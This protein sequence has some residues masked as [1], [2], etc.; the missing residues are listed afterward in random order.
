[1]D[2]AFSAQSGPIVQ[3]TSIIDTQNTKSVSF[4]LGNT[5]LSVANALRRT[6][7]AEVPTVAIDLVEFESNSSVLTDE[8]LAHR[9]GL[10]PLNSEQ[11]GTITYT[12]DCSCTQYCPQCSVELHL[13][14]R[15][16]EE[17][18]REVTSRDLISSHSSIMP[19]IHGDDDSGI[20]IAKLR[21]GQEINLRCIAKKGTAKEHAKW[22]PC[23][24]IAF[25]YD[26]HNR[27]RHTTY[28]VEDDIKSEWP[29]SANGL[30][31]PEVVDDEPFD[32]NAKPD[33]FYMTV[34]G[35]GAIDP[36]EIVTTALRIMQTKL[37]LVQMLIKEISDDND[38]SS[39]AQMNGM[40]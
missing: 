18:T 34:E 6:M 24:G 35:T 36:K 32:F 30:L 39:R 28:W 17:F 31:E 40:Y 26:P 38:D 11:V 4:I 8:F 13:N 7:I 29:V 27:L 22:S 20:M 25:E 19:I 14:V 23:A 2:A 10:I 3:V 21:K 1:M 12:R 16:D 15:C 33:K 9:L 37:S 5:D